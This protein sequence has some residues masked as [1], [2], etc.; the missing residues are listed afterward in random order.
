MYGL[1]DDPICV[2]RLICASRSLHLNLQSDLVQ[3]RRRAMHRLVAGHVA[4]F[5][6]DPPPVGRW[7]CSCRVLH[8]DLRGVLF[9]QWISW[10]FDDMDILVDG[11]G[12]PL[13]W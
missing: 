5:L 9:E 7:I 6:A 11:R 4:E 10:R 12:V 13:G 8:R 3:Q 2:G 1:V